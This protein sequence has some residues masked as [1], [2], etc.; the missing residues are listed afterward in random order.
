MRDITGIAK[1]GWDYLWI[2]YEDSDNLAAKSLIKKPAS[3]HVEQVYDTGNLSLIG[4][5]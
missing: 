3:V 4:F 1:K 2:R 5:Y